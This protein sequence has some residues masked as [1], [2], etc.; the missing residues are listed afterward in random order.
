M[1]HALYCG[2]CLANEATCLDCLIAA[3]VIC[4]LSLHAGVSERNGYKYVYIIQ[5]PPNNHITAATC[6]SKISTF[7]TFFKESI[8][9]Y[10]SSHTHTHTHT[11]TPTH[12]RD[13]DT[14]THRHT[15][16]HTHNRF[17][18]RWYYSGGVGYSSSCLEWWP[19]F[20]ST[21]IT[22]SSSS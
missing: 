4:N 10:I 5:P 20:V 1:S 7:L 11:H 14:Q 21:V 16:T 2:W 17:Y 3:L 13:T 8:S 19:W 6:N 22:L 9:F 15:H 18:P 12:H